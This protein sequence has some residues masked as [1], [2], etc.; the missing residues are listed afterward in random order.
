MFCLISPL[1]PEVFKFCIIQIKNLGK[2]K[3]VTVWREITNI[4]INGILSTT[5]SFVK[6]AKHSTARKLWMVN[7]EV[8]CFHLKKSGRRFQVF[9]LRL[10]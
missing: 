4:C 10:L 6:M 5:S 7:R 2:T 8:T 3:V 9:L 1:I